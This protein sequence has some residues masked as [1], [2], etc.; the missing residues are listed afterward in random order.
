MPVLP[1]VHPVNGKHIFWLWYISFRE[2]WYTNW[3]CI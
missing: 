3:Q 1:A 2:T